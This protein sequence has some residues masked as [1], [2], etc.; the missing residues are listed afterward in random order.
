MNII[1]LTFVQSD[2]NKKTL[3]GRSVTNMFDL[4]A[5]SSSYSDVLNVNKTNIKHCLKPNNVSNFHMKADN[6]YNI[7]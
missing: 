4:Y 2:K 3:S 6:G 7:T 5:K 1:F